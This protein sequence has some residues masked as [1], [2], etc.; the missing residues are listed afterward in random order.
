[1]LGSHGAQSRAYPVWRNRQM[2]QIAGKRLFGRQPLLAMTYNFL[3]LSKVRF[4][5][6]LHPSGKQACVGYSRNHIFSSPSLRRIDGPRRSLPSIQ[7]FEQHPNACVSPS[8]RSEPRNDGGPATHARRIPHGDSHRGR[9]AIS[10]LVAAQ[11]ARSPHQVSCKGGWARA[12]QSV[13][14]ESGGV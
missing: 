2:K 14:N 8:P 4:S 13:P 10:A 1:M 6:T 12:G 9:S 3:S 7:E 5:R 11:R